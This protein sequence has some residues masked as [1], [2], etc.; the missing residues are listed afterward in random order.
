MPR[1]FAYESL[2]TLPLLYGL[3]R[4]LSE[5]GS[6]IVFDRKTQ[7]DWMLAE[8]QGDAA[9]GSP[10]A[11][12]KRQPEIVLFPGRA[13][14]HRAGAGWI[15]LVFKQNLY[16]IS[17]VA[18]HREREW[19][20]LL[21][22]IILRESYG[23]TPHYIPTESGID[24]A[25][26]R[27]D[28]VLVAGEKALQSLETHRSALDLVEDWIGF[29]DLPFVEAVWAGWEHRVNTDLVDLV[30]G[31]EPDTQALNDLLKEKGLPVEATDALSYRF[32]D[33]AKDGVE[34]V[35]RMLFYYGLHRDVPELRFW[36]G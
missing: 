21:A 5:A 10:L 32:D 8:I 22:E 3:E 11:Y 7:V 20:R 30:T 4:R 27:T 36:E 18:Y 14:V 13:V 2:T 33:E 25:L 1:I 23:F 28:A 17:T 24:A 15:R 19:E 35:F 6:D 12:A 9:L 34:A 29:T 31:L 16:D 26:E